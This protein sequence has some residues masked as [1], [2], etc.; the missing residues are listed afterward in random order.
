MEFEELIKKGYIFETDVRSFKNKLKKGAVGFCVFVDEELASTQWVATSEKAKRTFDPQ[1][2]KVD[3]PNREVCI[4][5]AWTNPKYRGKGLQSY[6]HYRSI[7]YYNDQG[8]T[9]CHY[10]IEIGNKASLRVKEK[11]A[12]NKSP[13]PRAIGDYLM[14]FGL[15]FWKETPV[16]KTDGT[17]KE[18]Q[19][20]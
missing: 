18:V 10:I 3:F 11:E 16:V 19:P 8:I 2:Y 12:S 13:A 14:I 6:I 5:D 20:L 7:Q 15:Q 1:P 4:G 17:T 9:K